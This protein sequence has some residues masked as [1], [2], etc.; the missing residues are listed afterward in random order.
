MRGKGFRRLEKTFSFLS[1]KSSSFLRSL[2]Q[3]KS[4]VWWMLCTL[5]ISKR[6]SHIKETFENTKT[7]A[8][9]LLEPLLSRHSACGDPSSAGNLV[10]AWPSWH[11]QW[12]KLLTVGDEHSGES[13][14]EDLG[15]SQL[16]RH[17]WGLS[18]SNLELVQCHYIY[19]ALKR[20]YE[21]DAGHLL[22]LSDLRSKC[23]WSISGKP[24]WEE[25][26]GSMEAWDWSQALSSG[27]AELRLLLGV[28]CSWSHLDKLHSF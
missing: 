21:F 9:C 14:A 4:P 13:M 7:R 16:F 3:P 11:K 24:G 5:K 1:R 25:H 8:R 10:C 2:P 12:P 28:H 27:N 17:F 6:A 23:K 22:C 20:A 18:S 19:V 26:V 15:R